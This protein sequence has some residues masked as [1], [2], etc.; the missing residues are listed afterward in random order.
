MN[1]IQTIYA[2]CSTVFWDYYIDNFQNNF[3]PK[4]FIGSDRQ[5]EIIESKGILFIDRI[6]FNNQEYYEETDLSPDDRECLELLYQNE[7]LYKMYFRYSIDESPD[8]DLCNELTLVYFQT[9]LSLIRRYDLKAMILIEMPHL[10][11]SY[12]GYLIFQRMGLLT[13]FFGTFPVKHRTFLTDKIENYRV[14]LKDDYWIDTKTSNSN[15]EVK[16]LEK[17]KKN[18]GVSTPKENIQK[19]P[20]IKVLLVFLRNYIL[21]CLTERLKFNF[22]RNNSFVAL[23]DRE[24]YA[25]LIKQSFR[26]YKFKKYYDKLTISQI[27]NNS[28]IKLFFGMHYE[29]ELAVHPLAGEYFDQFKILER[30]SQKLGD[31]GV[32]YVK[33]YPLVHN[34]TRPLGIIRK[35]EFYARLL[36]L[37]NIRFLPTDYPTNKALKEIDLVI[38]LAGTI[39]WE[40]FLNKIPVL[41]FGHGWY[42]GLPCVS[43]FSD[44]IMFGDFIHECHVKYDVISYTKVF[45]DLEVVTMDLSVKIEYSSD[46]MYIEKTKLFNDALKLWENQ[47]S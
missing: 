33:E 47:F 34:Y 16:F 17:L 41:Y 11:Y 26:R 27:E 37:G 29:P 19:V 31:Q 32:L 14:F 21:P 22:I 1:S 13:I 44:S 12:I 30:I 20:F 28:G 15:I 3:V 9:W 18:Y 40:G 23:S 46:K 43:K 39:G 10:P 2:E 6:K 45:N 38:T 7:I 35:K 4:V 8:R 25:Y 24:Y 36:K 42:G 5:K